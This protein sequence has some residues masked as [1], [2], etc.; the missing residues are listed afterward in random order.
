M[1]LH[2]I[3]AQPYVDTRRS[4]TILISSGRNLSSNLCGGAYTLM[5]AVRVMFVVFRVRVVCDE[6]TACLLIYGI[7]VMYCDITDACDVC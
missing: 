5:L 3:F 6:F 7:I 4:C 1:E 2:R